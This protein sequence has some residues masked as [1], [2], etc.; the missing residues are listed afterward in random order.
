[1]E[2]WVSFELAKLITEPGAGSAGCWNQ[3]VNEAG[4]R[5][6]AFG[7][8]RLSAYGYYPS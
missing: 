5:T 2:E 6:R 8:T 1:V 7:K 4:F 3:P